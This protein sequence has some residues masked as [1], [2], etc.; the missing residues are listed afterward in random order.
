MK[1]KRIKLT[2]FSILVTA[3]IFLSKT[4]SLDVLFIIMLE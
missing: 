1:N 2:L 3:V 4:D